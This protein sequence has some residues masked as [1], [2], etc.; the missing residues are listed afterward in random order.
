[1][2][3]FSYKNLSKFK[4][5][6]ENLINNYEITKI[7]GFYFILEEIWHFFTSGEGGIRSR[8]TLIQSTTV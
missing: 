3:F 6:N 7:F 4:G 1:M 5:M 8:G 2:L